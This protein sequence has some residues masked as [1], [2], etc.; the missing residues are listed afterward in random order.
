M[1]G[2]G[3]CDAGRIRGHLKRLLWRSETTVLLAGYQA[4]GTLGRLLQD[5]ATRVRIQGDEITV[6]ARIRM[7]DV[8]SG[9]ADA[10]ALTGWAKA[11]NPVAGA[12]FL[13]HGEPVALD[14]L[15]A[16]L[17][18]VGFS[19]DAV[20]IPEIDAS[21]T[22]RKSGIVATS[23]AA[24][25]IAPAAA[26]KLDWHNDRARFLL[27]LDELLERASTEAERRTLLARLQQ[28]LARDGTGSANGEAAMRDDKNDP[29]TDGQ[30]RRNPG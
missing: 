25:R 30:R 26:A 14:A 4:V 20:V 21:Y 19:Q 10:A 1:A 18:V 17:A 5:G 9:H 16:R 27:Q 8:Y 7:L 23:S 6:K 12:V 13:T 11:R 28:S 3:M 24:P 2:S 22:L 15:R 29:G